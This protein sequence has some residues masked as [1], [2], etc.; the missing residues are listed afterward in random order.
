MNK[1]TFNY[2][3]HSFIQEIKAIQTLEIKMSF[4]HQK[5][6][7]PQPHRKFFFYFHHTT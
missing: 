7:E 3:F 5:V 1:Y 6:Q 2:F 4:M